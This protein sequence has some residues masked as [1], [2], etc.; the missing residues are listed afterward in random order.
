[1]TWALASRMLREAAI[2]LLLLIA[3]AQLRRWTE[4]GPF[5]FL[6]WIAW[7]SLVIWALIRLHRSGERMKSSQISREPGPTSPSAD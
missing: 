2:F 1:M 5:H 4:D 3:T 7:I 6:F